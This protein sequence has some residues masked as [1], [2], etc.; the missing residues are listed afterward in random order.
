MAAD[1]C[2]LPRFAA[3]ELGP[4]LDGIVTC[5]VWVD[6]DGTV[7]HLT[8]KAEDFFGVS[9]NQI[10]GRPLRDLLRFH[11]ELD[12]LIGRDRAASAQ[13]S[14]RELAIEANHGVPARTVDV[15]VSPF[16]APGR[17]GGLLVEIAGVT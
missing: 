14:R 15:T 13:Y 3:A 4:L 12:A 2:P 17:P 1:Q 5:I 6:A 8:E 16:D 7:L 11:E 10:A 9:L